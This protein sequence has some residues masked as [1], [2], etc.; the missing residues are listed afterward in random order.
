MTTLIAS[1]TTSSSMLTDEMLAR[2]SQRASTY[3][4]ENRFFDEDFDEL[5]RR[6]T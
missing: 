3:D 5:R 2:F 4:R 1:Q 6:V